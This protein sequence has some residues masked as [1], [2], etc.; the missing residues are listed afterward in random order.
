M[1]TTY[2]CRLV[3]LL[4][5]ELPLILVVLLDCGEQRSALNHHPLSARSTQYKY[6]QVVRDCYLPHLQQ[7]R[8]S[9]CPV[10]AVVS[11]QRC[12][13]VG[14][15]RFLYLVPVLLDTALCSLWEGL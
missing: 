13:R 4:S 3:D 1:L 7:T 9:A 2:F 15:E 8:H 5:D 12:N 10:S 11:Q 14:E 6:T